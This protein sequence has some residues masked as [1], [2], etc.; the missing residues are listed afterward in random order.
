MAQLTPRFSADRSVREYTEKH[1]LPAAKAYLER[2]ANKGE[3]GKQ[4]S[5]TIHYLEQKWDS[6]LFG[7]VKV[8]TI[9]NQHNFEVQVYLNEVVPNF[10]QVE[11]VADGINNEPP[12]V[13]IM[14]LSNKLEGESNAWCYKASVSVHLP[15][16]DF[17]ARVIPHIPSVSVPLEISNIV[18]QR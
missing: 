13:Q 10:V 9:E 6:I 12:I 15:A 1:Y 16:S 14:Q 3:K 2:S 17:T 5:D 8:N 7:E 4:L 18:W 11:L